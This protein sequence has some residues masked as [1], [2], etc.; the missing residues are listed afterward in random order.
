MRADF[1]ARLRQYRLAHAKSQDAL[2]EELGVSRSAVAMYEL[3]LRIPG[4]L[5]KVKIARLL[6]VS[7]Q[8]LFYD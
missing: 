1:G 2:A 8:S 7:I 5:A 6:G 4:D 3:G